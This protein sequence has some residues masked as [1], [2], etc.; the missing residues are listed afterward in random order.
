MSHGHSA[1]MVVIL[2]LIAFA[3]AYAFD[4]IRPAKQ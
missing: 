3:I 4:P 1:L 2:A